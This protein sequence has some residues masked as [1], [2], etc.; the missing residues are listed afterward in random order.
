MLLDS[1]QM[2]AKI[3]ALT[4]CDNLSML[5]VGLSN[6]FIVSYTLEIESFVYTSSNAQ[7]VQNFNRPPKQASR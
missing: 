4:F 2:N 5:S 6:G 7:S 1:Q 3:T